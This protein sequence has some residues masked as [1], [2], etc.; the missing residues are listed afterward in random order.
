MKKITIFILAL[1]FIVAG[2]AVVEAE[3]MQAQVISPYTTLEKGGS[4]LFAIALPGEYEN[5]WLEWVQGEFE[6]YPIFQYLDA[7]KNG[8][9]IYVLARAETQP[10]TAGYHGMEIASDFNLIFNKYSDL[11]EGTELLALLDGVYKTNLEYIP[12]SVVSNPFGI[13]QIS[14][15]TI[16][17][18][19]EKYLLDF[20]SETLHEP[21]YVGSD[22]YHTKE[23]IIDILRSSD[24]LHLTTG[25]GSVGSDYEFAVG[26]T[27]RPGFSTNKSLYQ[28]GKSLANRIE[29]EMEA[30]GKDVTFAKAAKLVPPQTD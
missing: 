17:K 1:V 27:L 23:L 29:S 6:G 28:L 26:L 30:R 14:S 7:K 20:S 15:D 4:Y 3:E 22:K 12:K 16:P 10:S 24:F 13:K 2:A 25:I 19:G 9:N 8:Q 21:N 18:N 5:G 11:C